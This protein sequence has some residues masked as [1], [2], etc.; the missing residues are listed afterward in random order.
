MPKIDSRF[1]FDQATTITKQIVSQV[2]KWLNKPFIRSWPFWAAITCSLCGGMV[3]ISL[4]M[5]LNPKAVPNCPELFLP[6]AS[7]SLRVYCGQAAASKQTLKDL[8]AAFSFVKDIPKDDP[9]RGYIDANIQKWSMDLIRLAEASYQQGNIDE[10]VAMAKLVP[11]QVLAYQRAGKRVD[12]WQ[13]TWKAAQEIYDKTENLLRNSNWVAAS[14]VAAKL[15]RLGNDYWSNVK[16]PE[17]TSKVSQAEKDSN[18]LD[19]ARKLAKSNG[20]KDLLAAIAIARK[21]D[22]Q[23]YAYKESQDLIATAG[24]QMLEMAKVQL[25]QNNWKAVQEITQQIPANPEIQAELQDIRSIADAQAAAHRNTISDLEVAISTAQAVKPTSTVYSRAQELLT[26]WQLEV[27]D[28]A[29]LQRAKTMAAAGDIGGFEAAIKEVSHIPG[30]NPRAAEA[31]STMAGWRKQIQVIQDQPYIDA[32]DQ[33]ASA[34]SVQALQQATAQLR[35][36]PP[37]RALYPDAQHKIKQWTN[38]I[39]KMQDAPI[40]ENAELQARDGNIPAA[41]ATANQ[42]G[43]GRALYGQAQARIGDWNGDTEARQRLSDAQQLANEG[44]PEALLGAIEAVQRVPSKSG[45][46]PAAQA[47][48]NKWSSEMFRQAQAAAS[49]DLGRAISIA[50][51]IPTGSTAYAAAQ[52]A[53]QQWENSQSNPAGN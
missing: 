49:Y 18:Q 32:A 37:G 10:A 46:Y 34:G 20:L 30:T 25:R 4:G 53:I 42:I 36:L 35:Q 45:A 6:M 48:A 27:Q 3:Y 13:T 19:Q 12:H 33:L 51:V 23:S 31:A 15:N 14:Q 11:P 26:G 43:A 2:P 41:I 28:L 21:I 44:T 38:Q 7:A 17:L 9:L 52:R 16:Y 50:Q 22:K 47:A 40:L 8:A 24:K 5:L 29:Y 39:Q 1:N